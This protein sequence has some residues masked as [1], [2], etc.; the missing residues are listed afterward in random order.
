MYYDPSIRYQESKHFIDGFPQMKIRPRVAF[1]APLKV[2]K[3]DDAI[4]KI[5]KEM[6]MIYPPGIPII[7]PGEVFTRQVIDEIEYYS[8]IK[9]TILSDWNNVNEVSVVDEDNWDYYKDDAQE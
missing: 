7:V 5:S 4:N 1:H 3:I 2:S 6:I 9:A 8:K